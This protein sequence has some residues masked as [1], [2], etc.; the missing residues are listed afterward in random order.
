MAAHRRTAALGLV[1]AL[2][3]TGCQGESADL[4]PPPTTPP[5]ASPTP[6]PVTTTAATQGAGELANATIAMPFPDSGSDEICPSAPITYTDGGHRGTYTMRDGGESYWIASIAAVARADVDRD[7]TEEFIAKAQCMASD[8]ENYRVYALRPDGQGGY[9]TLGVI[10]G[11]DRA[12]GGDIGAV[13]D[14]GVTAAGEVVVNVASR[15]NSQAPW[16]PPVVWQPRTYA[17][18]GQAFAQ[19]AGPTT[20]AADPAVASF[21]VTPRLAAE[22][23]PS[24]EFRDGTLTV[25]IEARGPQPVATTL[26][27]FGDGLDAREG[28]DWG[29]CQHR[30]D[31][32]WALCDLGILS[33]GDR[34]TIALPVRLYASNGDGF[35]YVQL[36]TDVFEHGRVQIPTP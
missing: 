36:R 15:E 9:A 17:W 20:F 30:T 25:G 16:D 8:G 19:T 12:T 1:L 10:V 26:L 32:D 35:G 13:G 27:V 31:N 22:G 34:R 18:N 5:E 24:A 29:Q 23:D 33:L 11:Q 21:T 3:I 4:V 6:A 14:L 2:A 28:G 7:G